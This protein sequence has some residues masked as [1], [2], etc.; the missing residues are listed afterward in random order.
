[1]LRGTADTWSGQG[2]DRLRRLLASAPMSAGTHAPLT[3]A[4]RLALEGQ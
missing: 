2:P 4:A 3:A 1:V